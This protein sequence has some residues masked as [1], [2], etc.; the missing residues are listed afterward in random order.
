M[1]PSTHAASGASPSCAQAAA[2]SYLVALFEDSNLCAIHAKR[3]TMMQKVRPVVRWPGSPTATLALAS[4]LDLLED[5]LA[6]YVSYRL[7][8]NS[9]DFLLYNRCRAYRPRH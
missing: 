4:R 1:V 5:N 7:L 3:V 8:C 2:E 6:G 9:C